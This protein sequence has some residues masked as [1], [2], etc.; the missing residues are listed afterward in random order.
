M[1]C[2]Q[3]RLRDSGC[4]SV[5]GPENVKPS[6]DPLPL[7]YYTN[8]IALDWKWYKCLIWAVHDTTLYTG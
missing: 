3:W 2:F 4:N 8:L 6:A 7:W 1:Y 5:Q